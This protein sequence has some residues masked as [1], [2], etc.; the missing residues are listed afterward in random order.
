MK[1]PF[2]ELDNTF[3]NNRFS[4]GKQYFCFEHVWLEMLLG[5]RCKCEV[6]N[7]IYNLKSEGKASSRDINMGGQHI[8]CIKSMKLDDITW[9][10]NINF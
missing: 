8:D 9:R 7:W 5:I 4:G 2:T 10:M 3:E 6:G 1:L